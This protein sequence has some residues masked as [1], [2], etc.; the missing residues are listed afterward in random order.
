MRRALAGM[1][2]FASLLTASTASAELVGRIDAEAALLIDK[3]GPA[4]LLAGGGGGELL[5]GY[6]FEL[7]P[8][9]VVAEL[10]GSFHG[11]GGDA[12]YLVPRA[13]GGLRVGLS[14]DVEPSAAI[15]FGYGNRRT[16]VST[17]AGDATASAHA[18]TFDL[19]LRCDFRLERSFTIGPQL[20]YNLLVATADGSEL[21]GLSLGGGAA[22]WW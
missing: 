2:A 19:E 11:A 12:T 5:F 13:V 21:H 15:H 14:L 6:S 1:F 10:G 18:F 9:I 22:V 7:Y 4:T 17:A 3:A 20:Q 8:V 16:T